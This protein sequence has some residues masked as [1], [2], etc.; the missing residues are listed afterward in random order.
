M[1][2]DSLALLVRIPLFSRKWSQKDPVLDQAGPSA[3]ELGNSHR[4]WL[5]LWVAVMWPQ[6]EF[7][8]DGPASLTQPLWLRGRFL[9]QIQP[10]GREKPGCHGDKHKCPA[11]HSSSL[12][13]GHY[14]G[15][16]GSAKAEEGAGGVLCYLKRWC[17]QR[18]MQWIPRHVRSCV[19]WRHSS[20]FIS[21]GG[22]LAGWG[23]LGFPLWLV[24]VSGAGQPPGWK[25]G[26][27]L[28][29]TS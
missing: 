22:L 25:R 24:Y 27:W 18:K 29:T 19:C 12:T 17:Q 7:R 11:C 14:S 9:I 21:V 20:G 5:Q 6:C 28:S 4:P 23:Q 13:P 8:K 15:L 10:Q 26:H 3:P 16:A 1:I 2:T